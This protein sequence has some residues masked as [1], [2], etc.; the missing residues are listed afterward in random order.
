MEA[1]KQGDRIAQFNI[2]LYYAKGLVAHNA[3]KTFLD[4]IKLQFDYEIA[5]LPTRDTEK[6]F[7]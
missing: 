4:A 2:G 1:A 6:F 3:V 7:E 5:Y